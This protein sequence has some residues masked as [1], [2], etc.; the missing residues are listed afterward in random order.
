MFDDFD[1][2]YNQ[3]KYLME[4]R[5]SGALIKPYSAVAIE[6]VPTQAAG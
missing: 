6:F 1:L 3:Q 2:D 4:S 5:C